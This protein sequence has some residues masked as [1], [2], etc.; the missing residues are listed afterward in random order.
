MRRSIQYA[1]NFLRD[2]RLVTSLVA[3]SSIS[4]NDTV[5]D[6]GAGSGSITRA[7]AAKAG[8][9]KAYEA[10]ERLA[11]KLVADALATP[12]VEVIMGDFLASPLPTEAYK[13]FANI[14]FNLTSDIVRKLLDGFNP[15]ADCYL[16]VQREAAL[17]CTGM[18]GKQSLFSALHGP[19][20]DMTIAHQFKS[21]DFMPQPKVNVVLL[22]IVQRA[23]SL[24]N[25]AQSEHYRDFVSYMFNH[26]NPNIL[27]SLKKLF[28]GKQ[29][30]VIEQAL[31][32]KLT[33]KPSQLEIHDWI[34]AFYAFSASMNDEQLRLVSGASTKLQ[35][36]SKQIEKHHRTRSAS[37]W[38]TTQ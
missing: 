22:R 31:G 1:Q 23:T 36:E 21:T 5:L 25:A 7:L 20:F 24:I 33:A 26:A 29:F 13:V 3:T 14:P 37:N 18:P 17:K 8:H 4:P 9:V 6:I 15:P 11:T 10:D 38:R 32:S 34:A 2:P 16:I 19:W 12:N 30:E 28:P 27:P 35:N